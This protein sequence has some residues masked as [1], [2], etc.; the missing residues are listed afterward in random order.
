MKTLKKTSK[1]I[2]LILRHKPEVIGINLDEHGWANVGELIEGVSKTHPLTL[3]I[4]EQIVAEDEKQ[5]YSFNDDKTLIRANQGHSIP[6][7]VELEE[8]EPPVFLYHGTGEKYVESIDQTGLIPK[9]RL[10]VHLSDMISTA[11]KVGQRHGRPVIYQI[12]SKR[13]FEKGYKFYLS[14]NGIWLT[15]SVP[16]KYL[17]KIAIPRCPECGAVLDVVVKGSSYVI[18]CNNCGYSVAT[19]YMDPIY[20]DQQEYTVTINAGNTVNKDNAMIM[21]GLLNSTLQQIAEYFKTAP[22]ILFK[23]DA[24]RVKELRDKLEKG[25]IQYTISPEFDY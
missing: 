15:D 4:L 8:K 17:Y 24:P 25:K 19:T 11:V 12:D 6:V 22:H 20:E 9:S 2:S 7:D 18:N 14:K 5:R 23:G 21:G 3:Q 16:T 13:M 1:Y 10:Y